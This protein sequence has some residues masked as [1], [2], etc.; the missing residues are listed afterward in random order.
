L[1]S[2]AVTRDPVALEIIRAQP[3]SAPQLSAIAW[4]AKASWGYPLHWME[5]WREELAITPEFIAANDTFLA[6]SNGKTVGFHALVQEAQSWRLEHLW[7]LPEHMGQGFGRRLF[8]HA[9]AYA[10][11]SGALF[12]AIEADPNAEP[13]YQRMGATRVGT[14]QTEIDGG[15]RLLPLLKFVLI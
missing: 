11:E 7:I 12:L 14:R 5:R 1:Q 9:A 2:G 6:C 10:A 15:V 3:A 8:A 13:F 4:A